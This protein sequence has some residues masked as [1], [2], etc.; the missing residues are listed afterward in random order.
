M[1]AYGIG[2]QVGMLSYSRKHE[3]EADEMGLLF[4]SLAG[5]DPSVAPAFWERMKAI[6]VAS[7]GKTPPEFLSTHPHPETRI[8]DLNALMPVAKQVY[9]TKSI[10]PYFQAKGKKIKK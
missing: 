5:Y 2:S 9:K 1:Q 7:G 4:M 10:Q 3:S 6:S 8:S